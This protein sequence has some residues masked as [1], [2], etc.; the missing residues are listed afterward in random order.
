MTTGQTPAQLFR[1]A[2][3]RIE[4]ALV[5]LN[6]REHDCTTCGAPIFD[7][8]VEMRIYEQFTNTPEK[9][10]VAAERVETNRRERAQVQR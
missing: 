4:T 1:E 5:L 9:L 10:R 2:A 6:A 8:K 3:A 7:D